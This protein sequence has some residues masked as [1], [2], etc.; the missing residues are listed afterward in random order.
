[1][2]PEAKSQLEETLKKL[3]AKGLL[4]DGGKDGGEYAP[5]APSKRCSQKT[6][7]GSSSSTT[8]DSKREAWERKV[9]WSDAPDQEVADLPAES[10]EEMDHN[11]LD[12][13]VKAQ[14][15]RMVFSSSRASTWR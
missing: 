6:S 7:P 11:K 10:E 3:Q 12:D 4:K 13:E 15:R 9:R 5:A 14:L 1:M 2:S 8:A